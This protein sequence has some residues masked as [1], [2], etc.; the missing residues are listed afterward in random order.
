MVVQQRDLYAEVSVIFDLYAKMADLSSH[1]NMATRGG[2][3]LEATHEIK[4]GSV[5]GRS[6]DHTP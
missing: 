4:R 2:L 6:L 3:E 1:Y 5:S